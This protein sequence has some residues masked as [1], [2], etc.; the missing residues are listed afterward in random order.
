MKLCS[1]H[2]V[3]LE[4]I[5]FGNDRVTILMLNI[6]NFVSIIFISF[7]LDERLPD[8]AFQFFNITIIV[9]GVMVAFKMNCN[10]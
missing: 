5:P 1:L 3:F 9:F 2:Y 4:P 6:S 10:A 7:Q 8:L